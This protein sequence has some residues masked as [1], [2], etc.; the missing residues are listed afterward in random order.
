MITRTL[1]TDKDG[2]FLDIQNGKIP[3]TISD[4]LDVAIEDV[5]ITKGKVPVVE[6]AIYELIKGNQYFYNQ[7]I[8]LSTSAVGNYIFA[9]GD[10]KVRVMFN[11]ESTVSGYSFASYEDVTANED[12]T[13]I[14]LFNNNR[15]SDNV[16]VTTL[17][18]N[19]T[20]IVTTNATN[21]RTVTV[22]SD[23]NVVSRKEGTVEAKDGTIL[24]ANTKYLIR[25]TNM[26][27]ANT[28]NVNITWN[29]EV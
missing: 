19:P 9:T 22:G 13:L 10:K 7:P 12:G 4:T 15:G 26:A 16:P 2:D 8:S 21:L 24:K 23:G 27:T 29:E 5:T 6:G 17:R 25:I 3:V 1:P 28:I 11:L 14:T 20:G 18:Y